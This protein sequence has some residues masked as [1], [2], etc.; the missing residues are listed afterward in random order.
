MNT[1]ESK[2]NSITERINGAAFKVGSKLGCGF[3]EKCYENALVY[4][5]KKAG[6]EVRQQAPIQVWYVDIVVG[7]FFAFCGLALI[8]PATN[9]VAELA[10]SAHGA[11]LWAMCVAYFSSAIFYVK[12][13]VKATVPRFAEEH[14][15][16]RLY[17]LIYHL[18]LLCT[19]EY[20]I[21]FLPII[22][23]GLWYAI[24]P[25]KKINLKQIGWT[26]V[27][28]SIWFLVTLRFF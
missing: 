15:R 7:E 22:V 27:V 25:S 6:F 14:K 17:T 19:M 10:W 4:E 11:M 8:A 20:A 1:D 18:L 28:Y 21:C 2:L 16:L 5:L 12:M 13:R 26:E 24:L 3:L 23:R 9:C